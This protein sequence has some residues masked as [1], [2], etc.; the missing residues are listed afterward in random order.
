MLFD[1]A[2]DKIIELKTNNVEKEILINEIKQIHEKFQHRLKELYEQ[3][4]GA[5]NGSEAFPDEKNIK[6]LK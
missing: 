3:E 6:K 5:S 4:M 1:K 2:A